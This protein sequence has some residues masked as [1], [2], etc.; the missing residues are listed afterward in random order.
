MLWFVLSLSWNKLEDLG[1]GS[2]VIKVSG[3]P[4]LSFSLGLTLQECQASKNQVH[5]KIPHNGWSICINMEYL[6][7]TAK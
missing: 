2:Q 6:K 3:K 7:V 1:T 5:W 4:L